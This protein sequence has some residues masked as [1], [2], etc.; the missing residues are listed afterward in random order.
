MSLIIFIINY[1]SIN[2][3][4]KPKKHFVIDV[5]FSIF[6]DNF[7]SENMVFL[8]G[9]SNNRIR[10]IENDILDF[11]YIDGGH[12]YETVRG[13]IKQVI[14]KLNKNAIIQF[15]DYCSF[16]QFEQIPYGVRSAV[17]DFINDYDIEILGLTLTP[18]GYDDI[19]MKINF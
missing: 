19:A 15:N 9:N 7:K 13:D 4:F 12:D 14:P 5:N 3:I 2:Y 8:E 17:N 11:V 6:K 1:Y 16:S 18:L 10:E